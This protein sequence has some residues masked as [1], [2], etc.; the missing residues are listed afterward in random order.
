MWTLWNPGTVQFCKQVLLRCSSFCHDISN[1][2]S[3]GPLGFERSK[4]SHQPQLRHP[5]LAPTLLTRWDPEDCQPWIPEHRGSYITNH[6]TRWNRPCKGIPSSPRHWAFECTPGVNTTAKA[7]DFG[8]VRIGKQVTQQRSF[9]SE[10]A[11]WGRK[12]LFIFPMS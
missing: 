10:L 6:I 1:Q 12:V 11:D 5:A 9:S 8:N 4:Q 7:Q 3:G 2:R